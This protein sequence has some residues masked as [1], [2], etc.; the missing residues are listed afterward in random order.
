[1]QTVED[2]VTT[3]HGRF[4]IERGYDPSVR[5]PDFTLKCVGF[6]GEVTHRD[7]NGVSGDLSATGFFVSVPC[8]SPEL[9][10]RGASAVYFVTAKHV[11]EDLKGREFYFLVNKIG[12]GTLAIESIMADK[13]RFHPTDKTAD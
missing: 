12:G 6:V 2:V 3:C 5:V 9:V 1:M 4:R 11:A 7:A 13:W 10:S 8:T